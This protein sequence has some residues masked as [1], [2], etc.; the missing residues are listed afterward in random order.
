MRFL[1]LFLV[2]TRIY[3]LNLPLY[4]QFSFLSR[5]FLYVKIK[6]IFPYFLDIL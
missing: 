3:A 6:V 2:K 1:P 4:Y 5:Y